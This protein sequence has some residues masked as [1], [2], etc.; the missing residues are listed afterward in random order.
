[1]TG[2]QPAAI[3]CYAQCESCQCGYC[4]DPPQTHGW[5]GPEDIEHAA[6]TGLPEPA[7]I[8]ACPCAH[9]AAEQPLSKASDEGSG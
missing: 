2:Q 9:P 7:G 8:C 4:Y 5:A 1:M 3:I 6:A